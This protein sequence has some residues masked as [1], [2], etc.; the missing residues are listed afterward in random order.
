MVARGGQDSPSLE[1]V[2]QRDIC[3]RPNDLIVPVFE[4][5]ADA[6]AHLKLP[7]NRIAQPQMAPF[8]VAF[9]YEAIAGLKRDNLLVVLERGLAK[10][11]H[12]A[13]RFLSSGWTQ[14]C[15]RSVHKRSMVLC[16][17]VAQDPFRF[18]CDWQCF[19]APKAHVLPPD[20]RNRL[21]D[22][23]PKASQNGGESDLC[24]HP[25]QWGAKAV[26]G[27]PAQSEVPVIL[28]AK[29]QAI[30]IVKGLGIAVCGT[31]YGHYRLALEDLF[32][33][34]LDVGRSQ[35]DGVLDGTVVAKQFLHG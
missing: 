14:Y 20:E 16:G 12:S 4:H 30:W 23:V 26:V 8:L 9:G 19:Q 21:D 32:T 7:V 11:G 15:C 3:H 22:Q 27:R 1:F 25:G 5:P 34:Q 13:Q 10:V 2:H 33:P 28:T 29:I 6:P 18:E 24:L 35:A 17:L 31:H